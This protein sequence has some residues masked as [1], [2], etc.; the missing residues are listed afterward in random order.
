MPAWF[1]VIGD[2]NGNEIIAPSGRTQMIWIPD[3]KFNTDIEA[4]DYVRR[5]FNAVVPL[6]AY[7]SDESPGVLRPCPAKWYLYGTNR[8]HAE[9][10]AGLRPPTDTLQPPIDLE[11][12]NPQPR[13]GKSLWRKRILS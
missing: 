11:S 6:R 4:M 9:I 3:A 8:L 7:Q 2:K 5:H 1:V 13:K 12:L 10:K